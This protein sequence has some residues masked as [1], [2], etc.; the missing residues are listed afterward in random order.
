M[1]ISMIN[2]PPRN[3]FQIIGMHFFSPSV[4]LSVTFRVPAITYLCIDWLPSNLVQM[5]SSLRR[6]A[7]T[8][9]WIHT[10][11][12]KHRTQLVWCPWFHLSSNGR[13]FPLSICIY[14]HW[15]WFGCSKVKKKI[16]NL[17]I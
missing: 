7:L 10:S 13:V 15:W 16:F 9:I 6:C 12:V 17:S 5:L 1:H 3:A 4:R 2:P 11:K 14:L 8:L